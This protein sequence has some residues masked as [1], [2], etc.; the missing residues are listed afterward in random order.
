MTGALLWATRG[1]DQALDAT[2]AMVLGAMGLQTHHLALLRHHG[3]Q[4]AAAEGGVGVSTFSVLPRGTWA[5]TLG[6]HALFDNLGPLSPPC[7]V[8]HCLGAVSQESIAGGA[9]PNL[10]W[11]RDRASAACDP[12]VRK[13]L[14]PIPT[15]TPTPAPTPFPF[16]PLP[17]APFVL[18]PPYSW[19]AGPPFTLPLIKEQ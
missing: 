19:V 1:W 9:E 8:P 10:N 12:V 11:L 6:T 4:A 2:G 15:P 3:C 16:A 5:V 17:L 18:A 13:S 14:H 7:V